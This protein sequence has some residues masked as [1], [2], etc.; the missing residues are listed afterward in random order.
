MSKSARSPLK[1]VA[2]EITLAAWDSRIFIRLR[3]KA[4]IPKPEAA[5]I[6]PNPRAS[7][8]RPE[9]YRVAMATPTR[10]KKE[11]QKPNGRIR[12]RLALTPPQS[13]RNPAKNMS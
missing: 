4:E 8:H 5:I 10:V 3:F 7:A 6:A 11:L 9:K 2:P 13:I 12:L 1:A